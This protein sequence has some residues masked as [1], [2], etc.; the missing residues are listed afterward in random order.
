M[1]INRHCERKVATGLIELGPETEAVAIVRL[2]E[3]GHTVVAP[4]VHVEAVAAGAAHAAVGER[5][6][7]AIA[8]FSGEGVRCGIHAIA[9]VLHVFGAA[10]MGLR[11]TLNLFL[12]LATHARG[13]GAT[14]AKNAAQYFCSYDC[15]DSQCLKSP[16]N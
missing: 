10:T 14:S 9:A 1:K 11:L 12:L 8:G 16:N 5:A 3:V 15:S 13:A 7:L 4:G 2:K 6:E